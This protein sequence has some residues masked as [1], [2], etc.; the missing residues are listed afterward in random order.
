ML[1]SVEV[2]WEEMGYGTW[3]L[4]ATAL[5]FATFG[6]TGI[7]SLFVYLLTL[8]LGLL[9]VIGN[10][11]FQKSHGEAK[12]NDG[13]LLSREDTYRGIGRAFEC[14]E[15]SQQNF[16]YDKR[17]TGSSSMDAAMQEVLEYF[18]RDYIE[19]WYD[20]IS[21]HEG[22]LYHIRQVLQ[23]AVIKFAS[24]SK[25]MQWVN[26]LTT[27]LVDD[28]ANHLKI[29]RITKDRI[30]KKTEEEGGRMSQDDSPAQANVELEE[31]FFQVEREIEQGKSMKN[32]CMND[33][34]ERGY[35]QDISELL[36]YLI[37]PEDD[38]ENKTVRYFLREVIAVAVLLPTA[39]LICDPDYINQTISWF[40]AKDTAW[41]VEHFLTTIKMCDDLEDLEE[42]KKKVDIEISKLRSLDSETFSSNDSEVNIKKRLG[43]LMYVR[44]LCVTQIRRVKSGEL[45]PVLF[46]EPESEPEQELLNLIG[47]KKIPKLQIKTVLEDNT[48]L[49]YFI[50]FMGARNAEHYVFFYL[51]VEGF[52]ATAVQ[53]LSI[54]AEATAKA[55]GASL[56]TVN[57]DFEQLRGAAANIYEEYLSPKAVPRIILEDQQVRKIV[58]DIKSLEPSGAYFDS[59]Q[60]QVL[61][62]IDSPKYFGTF[63]NSTAYIKCLLDMDLIKEKS[64]D[65]RESVEDDTMSIMSNDSEYTKE[66]PVDTV[67]VSELG[68]DELWTSEND[69]R[70]SAS[71]TQ[72]GICKD[73]GKSYGIYS[74][75]VCKTD[76]EAS[77][78]WIVCRRYSDFHDLHMKLK[79]K[80]S[81]LHALSL[82]GKKT[83]GNMDRSFIEKRRQ[84]LE[85]Y[86]LFLLSIEILDSNPGMYELLRGFLEPGEYYKGRSSISRKVDNLVQP[87]KSSV[88][89]A[90]K[91]FGSNPEISNKAAMDTVE[92]LKTKPLKYSEENAFIGKLS[93][94][95]DAEDEDNIPLRIL[96]LLMDEIF[97]LKNRNQWIRRRIVVILKQIIKT[98]FGDRINR[99]I[100]ESL[101]YMTSSEQIVEYVKMFRDS[102]WPNGVLAEPY[103]VRP[104]DVQRRMRMVTKA[105]M[106]GSIPDELKRFLGNEVTKE[107]VS[108]MFDMFQHLN[109]N[110]RLFY[111]ELESLLK[112]L[113]PDNKFAEIFSKIHTRPDD[114][115]TN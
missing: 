42:T 32:V 22:F 29:F 24:R 14:L 101:D 115:L 105:K 41:T 91:T 2:L 61:K 15:Q 89:S 88:K 92:S 57:V 4:I 18:L 65:E 52:R 11:S 100:V 43:S 74:I 97:D 17:L 39:E 69:V 66:R 113:F 54:F 10:H 94:S 71:I 106:F 102:F 103:Q 45:G 63:L 80:F 46:A 84:A 36:L 68:I 48:A 33:D 55:Q 59:A 70:L 13:F 114:T 60:M 104:Y 20:T 109:L 93:D 37:L 26:F 111:I 23:R 87:I 98:T 86:L 30:A 7:L 112:S 77:S 78:N 5:S 62:L 110:K 90:S 85:D 38:F 27:K 95:L 6:V 9:L 72:A 79:E 53:Q 96:L 8:A 44:K 50:E 40:C 83:F 12:Q 19:Y 58:R 34:K 1:Q 76:S 51:T 16:K 21:D 3:V 31:L 35:L 47:T 49:S 108:R 67:S 25:D 99:K 81:S 73:K 75:Q 107:G 28:F 64:V 56:N 82:P